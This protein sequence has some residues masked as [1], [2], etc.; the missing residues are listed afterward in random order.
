MSK[1]EILHEG[2]YDAV[3]RIIEQ[4]IETAESFP[5]QIIS[6]FKK[7]DISRIDTLRFWTM[8]EYEAYLGIYRAEKY[9]FAN[10]LDAFSQLWLAELIEL[11]EW[12]D[13][14]WFHE[15]DTQA[16]LFQN[17][18]LADL[19]KFCIKPMKIQWAEA[20]VNQCIEDKLQNVICER[21]REQNC[22]DQDSIGGAGVYTQ[23][24]QRL[25]EV[26]FQLRIEGITK[27]TQIRHDESWA[28]YRTLFLETKTNYILFAE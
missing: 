12:Y 10:E 19:E 5:E 20:F 4:L 7:L 23:N 14:E 28:G 13:A 22:G 1:T 18:F 11:E 3:N 6:Y 26:T 24:Q 9:L 16:N 2:R 27:A 25:D 21:K 17:F 8:V 15:A